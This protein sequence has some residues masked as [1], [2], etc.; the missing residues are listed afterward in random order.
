[1]HTGGSIN[2]GEHKKRMVN[3][4]FFLHTYTNI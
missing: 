4:W 2:F 3:L 1:L